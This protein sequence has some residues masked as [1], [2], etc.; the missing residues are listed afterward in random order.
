MKIYKLLYYR[1]YCIWLKKKD[2]PENAQIN[3]VMTITFLVYTNII[4]IPLLIAAIF[5]VAIINWP[6]TTLT[7]KIVIVGIGLSGMIVN[8][9]FLA[10][11]KQH[12]RI[13]E[14]FSNE[15][16]EQRKK[17]ILYVWL[18]IIISISIPL[19]IGFFTNPFSV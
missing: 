8:Y 13:L 12:L 10:R 19:F 3:S 14:L 5:K 16:I 6:E 7:I 9:F 2:E 17:G 18:Y 4:S 15:T 11:K 1:L